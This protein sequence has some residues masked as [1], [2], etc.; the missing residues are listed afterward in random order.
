MS[1]TITIIRRLA[2]AAGGDLGAD[3]RA[4]LSAGLAEAE[5]QQPGFL[6]GLR[7]LRA[8]GGARRAAAA[9]SW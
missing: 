1:E 4:G 7:G 6:D 3:F 5:R 8:E 2:E 9:E